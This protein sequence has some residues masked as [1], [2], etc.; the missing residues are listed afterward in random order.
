MS[1]SATLDFPLLGLDGLALQMQ[2]QHMA[3]LMFSLGYYLIIFEIP[4][5]LHVQF[6]VF[7]HLPLD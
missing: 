2:G 4:I 6:T 1:L 5:L 3:K 7:Y